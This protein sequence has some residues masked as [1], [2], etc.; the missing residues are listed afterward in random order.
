M[1]VGINAGVNARSI[2]AGVNADIDAGR[3]ADGS[4]GVRTR[5]RW[6]DAAKG[7]GVLLV[8][9]NHVNHTNGLPVIGPY[10]TVCFVQM[11][12]L[13][14]G[15]TWKE[16][17]SR[18]LLVKKARRLL[19]PY[20]FYSAALAVIYTAL[21]SGG[22][23]GFFR[24]LAHALLGACYSRYS[25]YPVDIT[26]NRY[27]MVCANGP[28]W[29]FP[30]MFLACLWAQ[31]VISCR[32]K[33]RY[34]LLG[35]YIVLTVC[36][37]FCPVLLPWS[38]DVS[39]FLSLYVILGYALCGHGYLE[40]GRKKNAAVLAVCL[41]LY[42]PAAYFVQDVNL[43]VREYGRGGVLVC[44]YLGVF[45]SMVLVSL[46]RIW[47]SS[48]P[49]RLLG[50]IGQN[51]IALLCIHLFIYAVVEKVLVL[52]HITLSP[53]LEGAVGI[54]AALVCA[55]VIRAVKRKLLRR[56]KKAAGST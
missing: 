17:G 1:S 20:L 38:L 22:E 46:C 40:W 7:L 33:W 4:A 23:E 5:I 31:F 8:L 39:F 43:S 49:V 51:T 32:S 27:F 56:F 11:F 28:M 25:L 12:F 10:Y 30:A 21:H 16:C 6:I 45:G 41:L 2:N 48:L 24:E 53:Y 37:Q 15:F 55:F 44:L 13:L 3:N 54:A 50:L 18:E 29:F 34:A 14:T 52:C 42:L 9:I 35:L 36:L 19:K 26:P 47:E